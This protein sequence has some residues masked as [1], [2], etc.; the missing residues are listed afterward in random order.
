MLITDGFTKTVSA[1]AQNA[2]RRIEKD[3]FPYVKFSV[4]AIGNAPEVG[5]VGV[6]SFARSYRCPTIL[7]FT[8]EIIEELTCG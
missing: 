4:I 8:K 5:Q 7:D 1:S 2:C 6:F 3:S